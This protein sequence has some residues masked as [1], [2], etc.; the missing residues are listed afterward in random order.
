MT[1]KGPKILVFL[2]FYEKSTS[3]I[4]LIFCMK[5]HQPKDFKTNLNDFLR[6][7]SVLKFLC[8]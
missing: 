8:K 3:E 1:Q 2:R 5:L 4:F 6:K 7:N